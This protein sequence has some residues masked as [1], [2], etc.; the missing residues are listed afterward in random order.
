M[1]S[2]NRK[3]HCLQ[4]EKTLAIP[5]H[6]LFFDVETKSERLDEGIDTLDELAQGIY[7]RL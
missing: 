4:R 1:S 5:R 7:A 2:I 3:A 6:L